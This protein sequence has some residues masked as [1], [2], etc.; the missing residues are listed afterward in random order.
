L[1]FEVAQLA[2]PVVFVLAV[3][4][5]V[6]FG[7]RRGRLLPDEKARVF[8]LLRS[9]VSIAAVGITSVYFERWLAARFGLSYWASLAVMLACALIVGLLG[10]AVRA[11]MN[12]RAED[13]A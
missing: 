1:T 7:P 2:V 13:A 5:I 12:K 4:A 3:A 8:N 9:F 6:I 11:A 10:Q